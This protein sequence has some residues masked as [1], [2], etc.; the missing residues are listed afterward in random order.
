MKKY[1][2]EHKVK[3]MRNL[4]T[5]N[6]GE[7][8]KIQIGYGKN[9]EDHKEGDIWIEGKK[10]WTIKNG[11]TQ[12]LT[13]LDNIRR[14]VY[15]P[16]TCPKC[17]NRVMKGD[18]DKLFWRLYGECSD[19]RIMYETN[20]KISGK[21]GNYEKD[22][23]TKNLKSW[24]KDLHSAAEDFIEE[25]NRSGYITETGKIEDWSKQNKKELSSIIRKR[26][27]NI[28]EDLTKRCKNMNKE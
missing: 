11:I 3:R 27:K 28:K 7:K 14:L 16:L 24:I 4:A 17:N 18:L 25:T 9:E 23:K 5:K 20:L 12:T 1:I 8:T 21:Y 2:S 6:F 15:M 19:C 26:V 13:K 10:T 22:I